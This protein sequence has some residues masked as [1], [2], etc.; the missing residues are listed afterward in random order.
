ML[1][2]RARLPQ[3]K[4]TSQHV[5][6]AAPL[7]DLLADLAQTKENDPCSTNADGCDPAE[8]FCFEGKCRYKA[9]KQHSCAESN[10]DMCPGTMKCVIKACRGMD[11]DRCLVQDKPKPCIAQR[12]CVHEGDE[13]MAVCKSSKK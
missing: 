9:G 2:M 7:R 12:E 11:G 10:D 13:K 4:M 1:L 8:F 5:Q 3:A 6:G